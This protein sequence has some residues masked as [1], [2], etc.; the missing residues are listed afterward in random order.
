MKTG[1]KF[2]VASLLGFC[3]CANAIDRREVPEESLR[4]D[5]F[6]GGRAVQRSLI[7]EVSVRHIKPDELA[8]KVRENV[9][10][11]LFF[12]VTITNKSDYPMF[13]DAPSANFGEG[14]MRLFSADEILSKP[15]RD[16]M[17]TKRLVR[18][19]LYFGAAIPSDTVEYRLDFIAPEDTVGILVAFDY[20]PVTV[21]RYSLDF[22]LRAGGRA[23]SFRFN[24]KRME[25]RTKGSDFI[26]KPDISEE[27]F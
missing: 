2:F 15:I 24:I 11:M 16:L 10:R 3:A 21:L 9:P 26:R 17:L 14:K 20:P 8:A 12:F 5:V 18:P 1:K 22:R 19:D 6:S 7:G 25:Y 23:S 27:L 13:A 4:V